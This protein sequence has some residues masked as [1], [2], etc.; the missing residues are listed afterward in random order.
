[1][2]EKNILLAIDNGT[3]SLRVLA[4]DPAG[5]LLA[6]ERVTFTPYYSE[7]PGWAE[8]DPEMYWDAL[9][10]ACQRLLKNPAVPKERIA[11]AVLTTQRATMVC[12]DG[13]GNP[14]R[15]AI[16]W[17]DQRK[18]PEL[19]PLG[20]AWGAMFK[21][22]GLS[23]TIEYLRSEAES[24]WIATHQ[25][26]IWK[27]TKKYLLLSGFLTHR[28]IGQFK[29]SVGCQVGYIPFDYKKLDWAPSWEWRWKALQ[30]TRDQMTDI[31]NPGEPLGEI[32]AWAAEQTGLPKGLPVIAG[33]AD[34]ACEVIGS[35]ALDPSTGA[36]SFGTTATINV[37]TKKFFSAIP[38]LPPFP[39]AIP[40]GYAAEIQ[41]YRG[42]WMVSWFK[43]Q[44]G[45]EERLEAEEKGLEAE[46]LFEKLVAGVPPGSMG[47]VLQPYWTPGLR[48][49]GPEGKGAIIGFGD[50][51]TK[52]HVYR[53]ILEGLAYALR[54][55][56]ERI[57]KKSRI[58]MTRLV[59]SGGGSQSDHAMQITADVFNLPAV[60][61]HL[62][63]TSGLG[64]AI[65][66]A[67]GLGIHP[68]FTT[69]ISAMTR[70]GKIFEPK[71]EAVKIYD[72]IYSGVYSKM[73]PRLKPLYR[74]IREITGYPS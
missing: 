31:V 72:E 6:K 36:V 57:E 11:G 64:A 1:M 68:D 23:G 41:V 47:L 74:R 30:I 34:K 54:E 5:N 9:C 51:H 13:D 27:R 19:K 45:Y 40:G 35:G 8:Q 62:F 25:P 2:S 67:V 65:D 26:D 12:V 63:E 3:Q 49:P 10:T 37:A 18:T 44:F 73:Y 48:N 71:D 24:S 32:T 70:P 17:L 4:F 33:A 16:V 53:A 56:R 52:A 46:V 29:D 55:G 20:G 58:P 42:F 21:A 61:P 38:L 22:T 28:L 15:P 60:R 59:V 50:V 43:E 66:L 7:Q 69:A 39:S 14:L